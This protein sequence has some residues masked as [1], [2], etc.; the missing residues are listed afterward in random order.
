M[1]VASEIEVFIGQG[2]NNETSILM[3]DEL[4]ECAVNQ[5]V[6]ELFIHFL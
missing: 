3:T 5:D 6:T 1:S 4:D 2:I